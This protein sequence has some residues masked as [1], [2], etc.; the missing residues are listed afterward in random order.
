MLHLISVH[1]S[2]DP[3]DILIFN[4]GWNFC[5]NKIINWICHLK[6]NIS[7]L[8]ENKPDDFNIALQRLPNL[9]VRIKNSF[10]TNFSLVKVNQASKFILSTSLIGKYSSTTEPS[11]TKLKQ[12]KVLLSLD[13]NS[14]IIWPWLSKTSLMFLLTLF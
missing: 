1:I 8:V 9:T 14:V 6:Q 4:F 7:N 11:I 2:K 13:V 12:W 3:L 5:T 10:K